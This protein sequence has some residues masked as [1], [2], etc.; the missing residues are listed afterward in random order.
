MDKINQYLIEGY[1]SIF[2]NK[3]SFFK[4]IKELQP[5]EYLILDKN[6][7]IKKNTFWSLEY[8]PQE[9]S[10]KEAVIG[11]KEKFIDAVDS[12]LISDTPICLLLS[13]GIDSTSVASV[14]KNILG[15]NITCFS[16]F[17]KLDHFL[18]IF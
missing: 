2:G 13:G 17:N 3:K 15:K 1:V 14:A 6:F 7:N 18:V 4:D 8:K 5:S 9:M 12:K 11:V 10:Y 16:I